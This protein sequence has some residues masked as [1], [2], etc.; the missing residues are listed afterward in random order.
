MNT[1]LKVWK[2]LIL[3]CLPGIVVAAVVTIILAIGGPFFGTSPFGWLGLGLV[4]LALLACPF[5]MA[6]MMFRMK[7]HGVSEHA[8]PLASCCASNEA[9]AST[10]SDSVEAQLATLR[11]RRQALEREL[12][13]LKAG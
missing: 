11:R 12:A 7:R 4:A 3:C 1:R 10:E 9:I 13:E 6:F 5:S 8:P 2:S